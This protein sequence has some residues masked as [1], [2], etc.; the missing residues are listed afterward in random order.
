MWESGAFCRISKRGGKLAFGVFHRAS[1]PPRRSWHIPPISVRTERSDENAPLAVGAVADRC[2]AASAPG[3]HCPRRQPTASPDC[4]AVGAFP[5][6]LEGRKRSR[7]EGRRCIFPSFHIVRV[8]VF[9]GAGIDARAFTVGLRSG[10]FPIFPIE[11]LAG[12]P[13]LPF[14]LGGDIE[15]PIHNNVRP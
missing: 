6:P 8:M 15:P 10:S 11:F 3:P 9:F 14:A 5:A 7:S 4:R 1:F 2:A 13:G 12:G